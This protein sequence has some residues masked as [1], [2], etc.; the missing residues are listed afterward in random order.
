MGETDIRKSDNNNVK[1]EPKSDSTK[2]GSSGNSNSNATGTGSGS[3]GTGTGTGT[4]T[5]SGSSGRGSTKR[6]K[7]VKNSKVSVLNDLPEVNIPEPQE[8][9]PKR[10]YNRKPKVK[11][12]PSF[13][14]KQFSALIVAI[15][16][17]VASREGMA[18][19]IITETEAEQIAKP[20]SNMI[21]KSESLKGLGE[22]A[23]AFALA[24][25]CIMI[26]APRLIITL[27]T[28]KAKKGDKKNVTGTVSGTNNGSKGTN[29]VKQ[30]SGKNADTSSNVM[31]TLFESISAIQ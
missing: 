11:E 5:G 31:P 28:N 4:G 30:V 24:T 13:D 22:H 27:Q 15:S 29:S 6:I 1:S 26:F 12:E 3:S 17:M 20:L 2:T 19:W 16:S 7:A 10:T 8:E 9:K 25:A 23:D 18:H 14:S 21:A